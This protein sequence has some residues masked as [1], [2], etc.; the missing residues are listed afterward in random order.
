MSL[1]MFKEW[2]TIL[3]QKLAEKKVLT[4]QLKETEEE[5]AEKT[6]KHSTYIKARWVVSEVIKL[7]QKKVGDHIESLVT[8]AIQSVFDDE[9]SF[10]ATFDIKR[11]KPECV[12]GVKM[13][14]EV[15]IPKD[16]DGG[17]ILD[18]IS[19]ALRVVL[20]TL[21]NP[22][23][24]RVFIL[25]EPF[26]FLGIYTEKAGQMI[27]QISD[28]LHIQLII[29]THDERLKDIADRVW[30]VTKKNKISVVQ[31]E[32]EEPQLKRVKI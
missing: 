10:S 1:E 24:E 13:D 16:E 23:S 17:G 32:G 27:R 15:Y 6:K 26:K 4:Q 8:M 11:N 30:N 7:T 14:D 18:V 3:N 21:Q 25:D 22:R 2:Q 28:K 12:L 31:Q 9:I 20:W 5:L 19:F 29:T